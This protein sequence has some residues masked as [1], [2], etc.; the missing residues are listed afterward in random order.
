M[1]ISFRES[2]RW[3]P[4]PASEPTLTLVLTT[5]WSH[6]LDLR[7]LPPSPPS[8]S[9]TTFQTPLPPS[10]TLYWGHAGT[11]APSASNPLATTWRHTL[12]TRQPVPAVESGINTVLPD[13][14]VLETG[15]MVDF[16]DGRCKEYEEVWRD[17]AAPRGAAWVA[18]TVGAE[19]VGAAEGPAGVGV[20]AGAE[21]AVGTGGMVVRIYDWCQALVVTR[22]GTMAGR[23]VRRDGAWAPLF[24]CG[25][26]TEE[27]PEWVPVGE[28]QEWAGAVWL[29]VG[30]REGE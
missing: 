21:E 4:S 28:R 10:T 16:D 8:T 5:P 23:W 13:G 24:L 1:T 26:M 30:M 9:P 3:L 22:S 18:E 6:Y 11:A 19:T 15:A 27:V 17:E 20:G 29:T 7:L 12:D 2:L 14:R 25:G